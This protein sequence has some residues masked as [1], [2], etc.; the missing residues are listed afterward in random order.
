MLDQ[1]ATPFEIRKEHIEHEASV[2]G[3]ALLYYFSSFF[4]IILASA[5][6]LPWL[7]AGPVPGASLLGALIV[8]AF[9][10]GL[11]ALSAIEARG[12]RRLKRWSRAPATVVACIGLLG[13][14][15]GTLMNGYILY[16]LHS[17]KGKVIFSPEYQQVVLQTPEVRYKTPLVLW[18]LL[19]LLI[20]LFLMVMVVA[21]GK[22]DWT[23]RVSQA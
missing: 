8:V 11:A 17:E 9:V 5:L 7:L 13:V 23:A 2:R 19:I 22:I 21:A 14:P 10:I 1:S 12:I 15:L 18:I 6:L 4:F 3:I 16:L 20:S